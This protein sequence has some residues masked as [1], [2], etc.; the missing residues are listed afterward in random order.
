MSLKDVAAFVRFPDNSKEREDRERKKRRL[1]EELDHC[2]RLQNQW[3]A[4]QKFIEMEEDRLIE[5]CQ[6][7]RSRLSQMQQQER[8]EKAE[9]LASIRHRLQKAL[10]VEERRR[11]EREELWI[12][13]GCEE[14]E[15]LEKKK[16]EELEKM[17]RAQRIKW[18]E[19]MAEQLRQLELKKKAQKEEEL[20]EP[21]WMLEQGALE[22][23]AERE[24]AERRHKDLT[25]L[26]KEQAALLA[27][28]RQLKKLELAEKE[29]ERRMEKLRQQAE[30]EAIAEERRRIL[31]Q[32]APLLIGF[33]PPG[34]F[35][36]M[37]EMSSLPE[38]IQAQF[39]RHVQIQD[40]PDLWQEKKKHLVG[41]RKYE[42][43]C[44]LLMEIEHDILF[45]TSSYL[46]E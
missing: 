32:H 35:R 15:E 38:N 6:L 33:L 45:F 5:E 4:I 40:D 30:D 21:L 36:N 42:K 12:E 20:N 11:R 39:R 28:R 24:A 10:E 43:N 23:K 25:Q 34:L 7:Q 13:Y 18:N 9:K 3:K 41:R 46:E 14:K 16:T 27:E 22:E 19:D 26:Q 2:I 1:A 29:E 37:A 17:T 8:K 31:E 44:N